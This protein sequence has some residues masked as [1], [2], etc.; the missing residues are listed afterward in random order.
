MQRSS[1]DGRHSLPVAG[2][3]CLRLAVARVA[4]ELRPDHC[5]VD[6][7]V[8]SDHPKSRGEPCVADG[9]K[10]IEI[11]LAVDGNTIREAPAVALSDGGAHLVH[12][13]EAPLVR[14]AEVAE[15]FAREL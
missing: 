15:E 8:A 13:G 6:D 14:G 9:P 4:P 10:S 3:G 1:T 12:R 2:G 11:L 7:E 5:A